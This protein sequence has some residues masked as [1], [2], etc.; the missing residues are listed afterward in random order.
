MRRVR[1]WSEVARRRR[2]VVHVERDLSTELA[3][4]D[5]HRDRF[6]EAAK[7]RVHLAAAVVRRIPNRSEAWRP[8]VLQVDD[9]CAETVA[10]FLRL[11]AN[12]GV[13]RQVAHRLP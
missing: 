6:I 11:I 7:V 13:N 1:I 4:V 9:P 8:V 10:D 3:D 12:A 2:E 5:V